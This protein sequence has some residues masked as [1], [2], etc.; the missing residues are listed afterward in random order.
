LLKTKVIQSFWSGNRDSLLKDNF[1]WLSPKHH[2]ISWCLS[3]NLLA[4]FYDVE[5]YTDKVGYDLLIEKLKLPYS[6]VHLV[7]D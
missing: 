7:M 5:L 1:G 2:L 6:K 3:S 4:K